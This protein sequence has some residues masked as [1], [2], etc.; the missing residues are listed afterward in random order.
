[1]ESGNHSFTI[2][3]LL[4]ML[5]AALTREKDKQKLVISKMSSVKVGM[6]SVFSEQRRHIVAWLTRLNE[7]FE[8]HPE[9]LFLS[10]A[11]FDHFLMSVKAHSKY[12]NCIGITCFYL[13]AKAVEEDSLVPDTLMLVR[14][15]ECGC[16][17]AEVLRMERCILNKLDWDL[18]FSTPL[19][20]LHL[21]HAL[22]MNQCPHA[23][24]G[25]SLTPSQ[26]MSRLTCSL[27]SCLL[28]PRLAGF[29]PSTLALTIISLD[30]EFL[31]WQLWLH[32]TVTLQTH[33]QINGRELVWCRELVVQRMFNGKRVMRTALS[34]QA[35]T[36]DVIYPKPAKRK[37]S[38]VASDE[39]YDGIK[40][41]YA[42]DTAVTIM[43]ADV[44]KTSCAGEMLRHP[45]S[46]SGTLS[47]RDFITRVNN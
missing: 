20:F 32:A 23:L 30:M 31:G 24:D 27:Q 3:R 45:S 5:D 13:A 8:F 16:S 29:T 11:I 21:Y 40:R 46:A 38:E 33:A 6:D 25:T 18:R 42:E 19:D 17:V 41:L 26:H 28:D 1:M 35:S 14:N 36:S 7:A 22:L 2:E 4:Q 39:F 10:I 44:M 12:L 47:K 15:S 34:T 43:P 9:T 37:V